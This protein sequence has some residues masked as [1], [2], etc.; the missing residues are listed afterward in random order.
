MN[1]VNQTALAHEEHVRTSAN[2]ANIGFVTFATHDIWDYT[3]YSYAVNQIYAEHH[4]YMFRHMDTHSAG[5][6]SL[7]PRDSRWNKVKIL[8]EALHS[9][10]ST[11]DY[12]VWVD[13]DVVVLD[14][15]LAIE[16]VVAAHPHAHLLSSAEHA[17]SSTLINSGTLIVKNSLFARQF[18]QAW[19]DYADRSLFS[20]QEQ[21]D[22]LYKHCQDRWRSHEEGRGWTRDSEPHSLRLFDGSPFDLTTLISILPPDAINSDPPAMTQQRPR[23]Q[24]LHLMGEHT[25][26]RARVFRAALDE[27][28]EVTTAAAEARAGAGADVAPLTTRTLQ[29]QLGLSQENLLLWTLETYGLES[30]Q[31]LQQ[32]AL[33][34]SLGA[35]GVGESRRLANSVHHYAHAT[36]YSIASQG[37]VQVPEGAPEDTTTQLRVRVW[38]L[39]MANIQGRRSVS[40]QQE[41]EQEEEEVGSD[42]TPTKSKHANVKRKVSADWPELLKVAAEAGQQVV[43]LQGPSFE[44]RQAVTHAVMELLQEILQVCHVQQRPAVMQMVAHMHSETG[45][46]LL[47]QNIAA[48]Q[49]L[50][51]FHT[52]LQLY[53]DLSVDSGHHILVQPLST[54]ANAL[55]TLQYFPQAYPLFE[56]AIRIAEAV[57]GRRHE[58][59]GGHYLNFGIAKVQAGLYSEAQVLLRR[60]LHV[61]QI[62]GGDVRELQQP[63]GVT[64]AAA[65][66][67]ESRQRAL[68]F[69]EMATRRVGK[70]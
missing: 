21:F 27:L 70:V 53:R 18:L 36:D 1:C 11:L 7:D 47:H 41:Q 40:Q 57:L 24:V 58:S 64:R 68:L 14:M 54:L 15:G 38:E 10:G 22:L 56:E 13:A 49:S 42:G 65:S 63:D 31:L 29:G 44:D 17:G 46:L 61:F 45:M 20:D 28:C 37:S 12:V 19:W 69:L 5:S 59:L 62:N 25:A 6:D 23:N 48:K 67:S 60:A 8:E 26:Y 2:S 55:C 52:S 30:A 39:L 66:A 32:Y 4:G 43:S 33:K 3:V 34:A 16:D 35:F 9:W 50:P 51:H